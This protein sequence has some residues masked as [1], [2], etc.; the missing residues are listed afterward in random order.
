M[1]GFCIGGTMIVT[2]LAVLAARGERPGGIM[3]LLTTMLDSAIPAYS[4]LVDEARVRMREQT[5]GGANG[6]AAWLARPGAGDVLSPAAERPGVAYVVNNYLKG[7]T[8]QAFDL[9]YWNSDGTNLPG[10]MYCWYLR[11]TYLEN[12]CA[13]RARSRCAASRSTSRSIEVP[14]Y[15]YGSRED[16]IVPWRARMH[17]TPILR[18]QTRFV[19]GASGHIAGVINP[20]SKGK[21]SYWSARGR[22]EGSA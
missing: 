14:T 9:L 5:I 18:R 15:I 11:N 13:S 21:R 3:T 22:R 16:H 2:A 12:R 1:F 8:P 4:S 20:A 7:G 10:P 6:D 17:S 19:L